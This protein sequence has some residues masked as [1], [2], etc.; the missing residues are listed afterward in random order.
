[1]KNAAIT[2]LASLLIVALC[3]VSQLH[4]ELGVTK[5]ELTSA[6]DKLTLQVR[7]TH[8]FADKSFRAIN[9]NRRAK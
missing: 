2:I 1:M 4:K 8:F 6:E 5:T 9:L 7:R 3:G